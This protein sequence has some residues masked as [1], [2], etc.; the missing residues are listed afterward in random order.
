[1]KNA[2]RK[3]KFG[4]GISDIGRSAGM[5]AYS[6]FENSEPHTIK[7][8]S[9]GDRYFIYR[10]IAGEKSRDFMTVL[11]TAS[12]LGELFSITIPILVP[13]SSAVADVRAPT[14][15]RRRGRPAW[16]NLEAL[17]LAAAPLIR[18]IIEEQREHGN[19]PGQVTYR[20]IAQCIGEDRISWHSVRK[21]HK[22]GSLEVRRTIDG[23][24]RDVPVLVR[25][26]VDLI[27]KEIKQA[28]IRKERPVYRVVDIP[29]IARRIGK[30]SISVNAIYWIYNQG[31]KDVRFRIDSIR[32][33]NQALIQEAIELLADARLRITDTSIARTAGLCLSCINREKRLHPEL[34][35]IINAA[36]VATRML[37]KSVQTCQL[38]RTAQASQLLKRVGFHD[39]SRDHSSNI[40]R[41]TA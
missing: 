8:E 19:I 32:R 34:E 16:K 18:T 35:R 28:R 11:K 31:P 6:S 24:Y 15:R 5:E 25:E 39:I 17:I 29:E 2:S 21:L 1:M 41:A 20:R 40:T 12:A 26:A 27:G 33:D 23:I 9:G 36:K 13:P 30:D 4:V 3:E 38:P 14:S 37:P 22:H 7:N 10:A